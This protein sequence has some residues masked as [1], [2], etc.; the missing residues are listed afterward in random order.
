MAGLN[1][2]YNQ[3]DETWYLYWANKNEYVIYEVKDGKLSGGEKIRVADDYEISETVQTSDFVILQFENDTDKKIVIVGENTYELEK[4][5][6]YMVLD[7]YLILY[8]DSIINSVIIKD[9]Q[10]EVLLSEP[11]QFSGYIG[12]NHTF[13]YRDSLTGTWCIAKVTDKTMT[14]YQTSFENEKA[15][16]HFSNKEQF[17]FKVVDESISNQAIFYLMELE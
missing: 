10:K 2:F 9:T 12:S 11:I 3:K 14:V 16:L 4:E 13:A 15:E 7:D 1:K 6:D 17:I 8:E 5:Q